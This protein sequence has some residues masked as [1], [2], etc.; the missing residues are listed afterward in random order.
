MPSKTLP[1][2]TVDRMGRDCL[3]MRT[4][5]LSRTVT[6]VYDEALRP[7]GITI[8]QLNIL[9]VVAKQGP[10]AQ[11]EVA[12]FLSMEKSTMSRNVERMRRHGWLREALGR[13]GGDT[14]RRVL[15][16]VSASGRRMLERAAPRWSAAQAEVTA[17]LGKQGAAAL[18]GAADT[19]W[20]QRAEP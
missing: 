12:R 1:N 8:G 11:G 17:L 16:E 3:A 6:S 9:A 2:P 18:H 13:G 7:L 5:L 14:A 10:I 15:L 20:A 19:I 4:R